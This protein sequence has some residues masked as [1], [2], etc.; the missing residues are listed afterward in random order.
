[1]PRRLEAILRPSTIDAASRR[2]VMRELVQEPM[3][4]RSGRISCIGVPGYRS[5]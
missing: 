2:S 3:K 5:I 1:M 4:M